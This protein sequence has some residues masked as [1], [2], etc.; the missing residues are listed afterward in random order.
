MVINDIYFSGVLHGK[1]VYAAVKM[2]FYNSAI[3]TFLWVLFT[4]SLC[5]GTDARG[6]RILGYPQSYYMF[7]NVGAAPSDTL[8][9]TIPFSIFA[10]FELSFAILTPT[11]IGLSLLGQFSFF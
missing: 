5:Y 11:L 9:P 8:A 10:M 6:N 2:A 7:H 1:D 3:V 4:F